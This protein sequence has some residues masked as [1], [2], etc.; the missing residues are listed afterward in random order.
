MGLKDL[1]PYNDIR[2]IP[3][4]RFRVRHTLVLSAYIACKDQAEVEKILSRVWY[5]PG[6]DWEKRGGSLLEFYALSSG[7]PFLIG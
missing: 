6:E 3:I 7:T 2:L 1:T 4:L 5:M